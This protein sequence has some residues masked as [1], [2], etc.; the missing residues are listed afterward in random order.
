MKEKIKQGILALLKTDRQCLV[1]EI[2]NY[3]ER[4]DMSARGDKSLFVA[5]NCML[6]DSCSSD[7][8][9]ALIELHNNKSVLLE[10]IPEQAAQFE[11]L[12]YGRFPDL[13]YTGNCKPKSKTHWHPVF[14]TLPQYC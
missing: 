2:I 8:C 13:P 1:P 9:S 4:N 6:W 14:I 11:H 12:V 3:L 7:F 5:D 10:P